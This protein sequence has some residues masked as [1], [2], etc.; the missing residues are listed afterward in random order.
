MLVKENLNIGFVAV[1]TFLFWNINK[2][3][4]TNIIAKLIR[5]HNVDIL[6]ITESEIRDIDILKSAKAESGT[7]FTITCPEFPT[8]VKIYSRLSRFVKPVMDFPGVAIRRL[9][10]PVGNDVLFVAAHLPSKLYQTEHDQLF[11]CTRLAKAIDEAESR[12]RHTRTLIIGDLNMNPFECGV[13]GA[14]GIHG[15]SDRR[16]AARGMRR[17]AGKDCRFFYNPMWNYLGDAPPGPPGTYFY[18]TGRQIN[19]Y[20][21]IFD[22]VLFRPELLDAFSDENLQV[23]TEVDTTSLATQSGRPDDNIGSD[24]FPILLSLKI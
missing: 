13:L 11:A 17:V 14:D 16:I 19:T 1:V 5:A 23:L 20:W 6:I 18:D 3:P 8:R 4:L 22:Q 7:T 12:V 9:M 10:L 15:V 24:H 21:N 2:R